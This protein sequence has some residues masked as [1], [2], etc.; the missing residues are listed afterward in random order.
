MKKKFILFVLLF[1][2]A[3]VINVNAACNNK[4]LNDWSKSV[5][6]VQTDYVDKGLI[7]GEDGLYR[8]MDYLGYA[9]LLSLSTP[10]KDVIIKAVD[11]NGKE[12]NQE[13]IDGYDMDAVGCTNNLDAIEYTIIIYGAPESACPGEV[14]RRINYNVDQYNRYYKT[15]YCEDYPEFELCQIY[16]DTSDISESEFT[17]QIETYIEEVEK[18][19]TTFYKILAYVKKY[20]AYV[21]F[22]IVPFL[23]VSLTYRY[24]IKD[25]LKK[26]GEL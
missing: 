8:R 3:G 15:R 16:K 26:H 20:Y 14:I 22:A 19:N 25:Y 17:E 13:H 24:K 1:F 18:H 9:Y 12:Y 23:L 4:E 5:Y 6:V 11:S 21:L 10:R 2:M 7:V